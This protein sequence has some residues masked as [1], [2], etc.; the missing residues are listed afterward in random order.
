MLFAAVHSST[1]VKCRSP[2]LGSTARR[3]LKRLSHKPPLKDEVLESQ[4]P[5]ETFF[6]C[7]K[8]VIP[9]NNQKSGGSDK[10]FHSCSIDFSDVV[11][12]YEM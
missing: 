2:I 3:V 7:T 1:P 9:D 4:D 5:D 10:T 11:C 8:I 6:D 12:K